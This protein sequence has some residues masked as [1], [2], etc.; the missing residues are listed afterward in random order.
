M[1]IAPLARPHNLLQDSKR[2]RTSDSL[3]ATAGAEESTRQGEE[4]VLSTP[5]V[6]QKIID[7]MQDKEQL[8][9]SDLIREIN[10]SDPGRD[11][12]PRKSLLAALQALDDENKIMF[13]DEVVHKV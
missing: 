7:V 1:A 6:M 13:Y 9:L 5:I 12:I 4:P 8:P 10:I 3:P 11:A 2:R